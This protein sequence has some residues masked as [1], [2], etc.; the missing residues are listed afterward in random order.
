MP[1]IFSREGPHVRTTIDLEAAA[2]HGLDDASWAL[3][4]LAGEAPPRARIAPSAFP[5]AQVEAAEPFLPVGCVA[6]EAGEPF[7]T[8]RAPQ[9][10]VEPPSG[11]ALD[12]ECALGPS[13]APEL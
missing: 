9:P 8:R 2:L 13:F 10:T 6:P 1:R 11:F 4:A 7:A 12:R 3:L 5:P